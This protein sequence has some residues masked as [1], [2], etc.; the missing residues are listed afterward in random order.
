MRRGEAIIEKIYFVQSPA[1]GSAYGKVAAKILT[2]P[3]KFLCC[4]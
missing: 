3:G 1:F 2:P 4:S